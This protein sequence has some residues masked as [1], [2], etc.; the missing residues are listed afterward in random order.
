MGDAPGVS[1]GIFFHI[2]VQFKISQPF[3]KINIL[4]PAY[5]NIPPESIWKIASLS[6]IA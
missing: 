6:E 1:G 2:F 4:V 5:N 3:H